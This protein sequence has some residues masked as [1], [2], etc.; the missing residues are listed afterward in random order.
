MKKKLLLL[1]CCAVLC[2]SGVACDKSLKNTSKDKS[3]NQ[4]EAS[5]DSNDTAGSKS[6]NYPTQ[7]V[8]ILDDS[9]KNETLNSD[10]ITVSIGDVKGFYRSFATSSMIEYLSDKDEEEGLIDFLLYTGSSNE[11]VSESRQVYVNDEAYGNKLVNTDTTS[12]E[13]N[14]VTYDVVNFTYTKNDRNVSE[15]LVMTNPT[16]NDIVAFLYTVYDSNEFI[17]AQH[18]QNVIESI[19]I[20]GS[21]NSSESSEDSSSHASSDEKSDNDK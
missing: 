5:D 1:G 13:V 3:H 15:A 4:A 14:G 10:T 2:L 8:V 18:L 16:D 21:E 6:D 19:V 20:K 9:M 11:K 7:S 12:L 17:D